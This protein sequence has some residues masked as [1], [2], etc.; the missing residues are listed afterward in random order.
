MAFGEKFDL[1]DGYLNTASIGVPPESAGLA[2]AECVDRWRRGA[3]APPDFDADVATARAAWA[4]LAG[5]PVGSV[6]IGATAAQLVGLVAAGL[7]EATRVVTVRQEFT[8]VTFPFAARG[9]SV[10]EVA[11]DELVSA[12]PDHDLVA[13]SVVQSA[14]GTVADLAGLRVV[15]TPVLLD[16]T[17]AAGWMPLELGWADWVVGAGYKWLLAPRGTAW[18]AERREQS[19][20]LAAGWYAGEDP[21]DTVYGLP[22]RLAEGARRLDSSPVWM[23]QVGA[24]VSLPWLASLDMTKVRD[25]CVGLADRV[26]AE[27]GERPRGSAIV[28][29]DRPDAGP[30]LTEAGIVHS[31][32]AGRVRV[33]FHLYSDDS[34]VERLLAA[35]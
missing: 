20:P 25:H 7:P 2:V 24:A 13:V 33:A 28:S 29:L 19:R 12:A 10:T 30:R 35:L 18:L 11:A 5:V 9:M 3:A 16:V 26:L 8:S 15:G 4:Q 17:Q 32:R 34:D 23:A 14:D 6:S 1:P 21:W 31:M 27:L 22:L